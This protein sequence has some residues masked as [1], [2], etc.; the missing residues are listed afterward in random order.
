MREKVERTRRGRE[1][2]AEEGTENRKGTGG[3]RGE[4]SGKEWEIGKGEW[5]Q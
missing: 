1:E 5:R 4:R 2:G 3:R